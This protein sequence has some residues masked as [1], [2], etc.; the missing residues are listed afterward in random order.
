MGCSGAAYQLIIPVETDLLRRVAGPFELWCDLLQ[1]QA[2]G[3]VYNFFCNFVKRCLEWF[4][5]F[6]PAR[7]GVAHR[8]FLWCG[9][10]VS[11]C[12]SKGDIM[13]LQCV[14]WRSPPQTDRSCF[15]L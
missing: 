9:C 1:V 10:Y 13:L 6:D 4:P 12:V 7:R 11:I 2:L 14:N 3:I 8:N 15:L 5:I